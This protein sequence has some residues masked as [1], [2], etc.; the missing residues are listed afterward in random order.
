M[1]RRALLARGLGAGLGS[2]LLPP[3]AFAQP[4]ETGYLPGDSEEFIGLWP[5]TPPGGEGIHLKRQ[6]KVHC[7]L[8]GLS[9]AVGAR[10]KNLFAHGGN[11]RASGFESLWVAAD[12]KEK[13]AFFSAPGT[14]GDGCIEEADAR[15][16]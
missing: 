13:F 9:R 15:G 4:H 6:Q 11:D 7:Q 10:V 2:A 3:A 12:H 14:A 8:D 16:S 1:D 5:G